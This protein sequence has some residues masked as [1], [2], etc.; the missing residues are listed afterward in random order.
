[1]CCGVSAG[2]HLVSGH[3]GDRDGGRRAAVLQ[4]AS[5][6]GHETDTRQPASATQGLS[7]G[8]PLRLYWS[9]ARSHD[10]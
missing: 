4:R 7:Q 6:A 1:M 8:E 2:G 9:E 10:H 5:A 3:H